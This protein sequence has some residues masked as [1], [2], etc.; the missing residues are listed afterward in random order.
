MAHTRTSFRRTGSWLAAAAAVAAFGLAGQAEARDLTVVSWGG[1]YQDAQEKVYFDPFSEDTG[2]NLLEDS[3]NGGLAKIRSMVKTD[4]VTWDVVQLE[5]PALQR[6]C[7]Q[8]LFAFI[9]WDKIDQRKNFID[10]AASDCGV[11]TIVWGVVM[12]YNA[13]A[14]DGQPDSWEDFW[15]VEKFPGKRGLRKGAK[16]NLEIALMADGVPP[17]KVY[18]VLRTE[19]GV[20]RAFAK[21][22]ELKPHI[23]WWEAGAQPP[24]WLASEDV[25]MSSAYNGRI[26]AAQKEGQPF[27]ISWPGQVYAIDSW[28]IVRGTPKMDQAVKFIDYASEPKHQA[29]LPEVIPYGPTHKAA[30]DSVPEDV[31]PNLPT[32]P[33]N[34]E[35]ALRNDT[36]FWINNEESLDQRFNSWI[37][38]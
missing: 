19:E 29:R 6:G 37:A 10:G 27:K 36:E 31:V 2:I 4:S 16:F 35:S 26:T 8:G 9:P 20:D 28:A 24:E 15:N 38:N 34:L 3:Y 32:A 5:A 7:Q 13:D 25:V 23:Q 1:S 11:G 33:K 14:V 17:E 21:L 18:D 12:A 30:I 22:E